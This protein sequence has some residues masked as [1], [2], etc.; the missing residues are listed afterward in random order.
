MRQLALFPLTKHSM[1][2]VLEASSKASEARAIISKAAAVRRAM[3]GP[4]HHLTM[5]SEQLAAE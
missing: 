2:R 3:L 1:G 4:D 5:E